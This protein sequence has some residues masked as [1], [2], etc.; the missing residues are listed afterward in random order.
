MKKIAVK[1]EIA[2][3]NKQMRETVL[4]FAK[5]SKIPCEIMSVFDTYNPSDPNQI[6]FN[7]H[8]LKTIV[9]YESSLRNIE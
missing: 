9:S 3:K 5:T 6:Y 2:K 4:E 8:Q 7:P 1:N